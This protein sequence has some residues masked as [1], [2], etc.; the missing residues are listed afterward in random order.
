MELW[1]R[2]VY[3][4]VYSFFDEISIAFVT[5]KLSV[6]LSVNVFDLGDKDGGAREAGWLD[7]YISIW[8]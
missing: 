1:S 5:R 6:F 2:V 3:D 8:K 7:S 4:Y